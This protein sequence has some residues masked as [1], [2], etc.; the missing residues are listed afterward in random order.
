[1]N[2][3]QLRKDIP[4]TPDSYIQKTKI[5]TIIDSN[6]EKVVENLISRS[7]VGLIK[8]GVTTERS[9]LGAIEWLQHLQ[10]EL[11]DATIYIETLK[12]K[13]NESRSLSETDTS[14]SNL[15]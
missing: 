11:M 4:L 8:Y 1:M 12:R 14:D 5:Y 9:D 2:E 6:V 15:S 13:F 7:N 10:E 3:K